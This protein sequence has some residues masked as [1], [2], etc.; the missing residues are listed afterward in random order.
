MDNYKGKTIRQIL[1]ERRVDKD[2]DAEFVVYERHFD[3]E[4]GRVVSGRVRTTS[5]AKE[6]KNEA[7]GN[8]ALLDLIVDHID[9]SRSGMKNKK[10]L[11]EFVCNY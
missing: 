4:R 8:R 1:D 5:R 10:L 6:E 11:V 2:N 3:D 9:F 7:E